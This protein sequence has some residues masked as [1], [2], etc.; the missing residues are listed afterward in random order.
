MS[1]KLYTWWWTS[2]VCVKREREVKTSTDYFNPSTKTTVQIHIK[3]QWFKW[4]INALEKRWTV[5]ITK[6]LTETRLPASEGLRLEF[7][8]G[9]SYTYKDIKMTGETISLTKV[10]KT[11]GLKTINVPEKV[12]DANKIRA[13]T[14]SWIRSHD[15]FVSLNR[16]P[17][18]C[19]QLTGPLCIYHWAAAQF[20]AS[21]KMAVF[22]KYTYAQCNP[23]R[24]LKQL[25]HRN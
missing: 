11:S 10:L 12:K 22:S 14:C 9:S 23:Y 1:V 8:P 4:G 15:L 20:F 21:V 24:T 6:R 19:L 16:S 2:K 7:V 17:G 18:D 13:T 3:G 25:L 5:H